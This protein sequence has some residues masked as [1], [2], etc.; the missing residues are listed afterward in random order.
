MKFLVKFPGRQD[1]VCTWNILLTWIPIC[2]L[3]FLEKCK[4]LPLLT[5]IKRVTELLPSEAKAL[6]TEGSQVNHRTSQIKKDTFKCP[7]FAEHVI[8]EPN[9]LTRCFAWRQPWEFFHR[10][11]LV[12]PTYGTRTP[13]QGNDN[14]I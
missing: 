4:Y 8:K 9:P 11:Q 1:A 7:A 13:I 12:L 3:L 10:L 14:P 2:E 5:L 6:R